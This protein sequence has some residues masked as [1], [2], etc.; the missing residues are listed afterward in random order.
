MIKIKKTHYV[1][2][3]WLLLYR[4]ENFIWERYSNSF[5]KLNGG[6]NFHEYHQDHI[7]SD[8]ILF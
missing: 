4:I 6:K 5:T 7:Y 3:L 8:Q 1:F 2:K